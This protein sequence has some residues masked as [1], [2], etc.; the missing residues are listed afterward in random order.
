M[1][2]IRFRSA[3]AM[4]CALLAAARASAARLALASRD[5]TIA[6]AR[7]FARGSSKG[8]ATGSIAVSTVSPVVTGSPALKGT[9][10]MRP[11][12]GAATT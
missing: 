11:L 1:L 2:R 10:R 7:T 3:S 9:R 5:A 12:T 4:A 6:S 8:A